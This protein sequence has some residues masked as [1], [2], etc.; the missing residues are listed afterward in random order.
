MGDPPNPE[1]MGRAALISELLERRRDSSRL[2]FLEGDW[3][4]LEHVFARGIREQGP[5]A[6]IR[7]LVDDERR[8]AAD[9]GVRVDSRASLPGDLS[10]EDGNV[11]T[12]TGSDEVPEPRPSE[13]HA[14]GPAPTVPAPGDQVIDGLAWI[15]LR[16]G[17]WTAA[18]FDQHLRDEFGDGLA[19]E[20]LRWLQTIGVLEAVRGIAMTPADDS[21]SAWR[22]LQDPKAREAIMRESVAAA[23]AIARIERSAS[24]TEELR[25]ELRKRCFALGECCPICGWDQPRCECPRAR[26]GSET[27]SGG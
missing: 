9:A 12:L 15:L 23:K 5:L 19:G 11:P 3:V 7:D 22:F 14:C 27:R 10:P 16:V 18:R 20:L 1:G 24:E 8:L 13:Q 4:A 21:P 2:D 26:T 17:S 6:T 25:A